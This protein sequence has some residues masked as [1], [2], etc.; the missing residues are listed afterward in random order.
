MR[1]STRSPSGHPLPVSRQRRLYLG[2]L[3]KLRGGMTLHRLQPPQIFERDNGSHLAAQMDHLVRPLL[4]RRRCSHGTTVPR[5]SDIHT[6]PL[7]PVLPSPSSAVHKLYTSPNPR[8]ASKDLRRV[9]RRDGHER[10]VLNGRHLR[11]LH[12]RIAKLPGSGP[13]TH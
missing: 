11:E 3:Q 12:G 2:L 8:G 1:Y 10:V 5:S 4:T 9:T 6:L 7:A 13:D